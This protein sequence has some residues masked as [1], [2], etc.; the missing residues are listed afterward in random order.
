MDREADRQTECVNTL[1][2]CW[3]VLIKKDQSEMSMVLDPTT[4]NLML[5]EGDLFKVTTEKEVE[6]FP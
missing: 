2:F 5:P 6:A 4:Q 3:K 1:N